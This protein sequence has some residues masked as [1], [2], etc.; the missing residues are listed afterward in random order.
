MRVETQTFSDEKHPPCR[1]VATSSSWWNERQTDR[2]T[3]RQTERERERGRGQALPVA[4][5]KERERER[6]RDRD[7]DRDRDR[8]KERERERERERET[9]QREQEEPFPGSVSRVPVRFGSGACGSVLC[10]SG[11]AVP[12]LRFR[13][14]STAFLLEVADFVNR[15][16]VAVNSF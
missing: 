13:F 6:E 11:S 15:R 12:V 8:E 7:R 16:A 10:G 9:R 1:Q 2:E 14:G 4:L 3:E 5:A